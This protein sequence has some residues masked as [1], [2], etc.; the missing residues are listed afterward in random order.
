M[1]PSHYLKYCWNYVNWTLRNKLQW[2][3]NRNSNIFIE[4]NTFQNVVCEMSAILPRP[5]CVQHAV[6]HHLA[7][8][9]YS[10]ASWKCDALLMQSSGKFQSKFKHLH[11][12]HALQKVVSKMT[13]IW[14]GP[15]YVEI[16]FHSRSLHSWCVSL[17]IFTKPSIMLYTQGAE[18]I[19]NSI[20][21]M[22][23]TSFYGT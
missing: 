7:S 8:M 6:V 10:T 11:S 9:S 16:N 19:I 5:Q 3:F 21:I 13:A 23:T 4:E 14:L 2:N 12:R 17:Q 15:K 18:L 22:C 1:A 20:K